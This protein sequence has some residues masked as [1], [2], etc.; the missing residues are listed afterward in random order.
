M[1]TRCF[2]SLFFYDSNP[3]IK[4]ARPRGEEPI[5]Q[6]QAGHFPTSLACHIPFPSP[7]THT[8]A[9]PEVPEAH[10]GLRGSAKLNVQRAWKPFW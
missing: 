5:Q 4:V 9:E 10:Q 2:C 6:V 7:P 1:P 8:T 3:Q